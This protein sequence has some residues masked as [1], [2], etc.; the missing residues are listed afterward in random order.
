[1]IKRFK[2]DSLV[3]DVITIL[4]S[5]HD[6]KR[7]SQVLAEKYA[8][9]DVTACI[10]ALMSFGVITVS[11]E[12]YFGRRYQK[13]VLF[14]SE[15]TSSFEEAISSQK[16]LENATVAVFGVGGV[17]TWIVNGL[18]QMGVGNIRITD[19]DI[20]TESNLNRQ[21]YFT[22]QDIGRYKVDVIKGKIP[23][24][25]IQTWKTTVSPHED[26]DHI[27]SGCDI[28]INCADTPS[29]AETTRVVS[30]YATKHNIPYSIAGGY[31]M[32]IGMVGPIFVPG[33]TACF[34]CLVSYLQE[35]D[36]LKGLEVVKGVE[37]T[38]SL[39]P[40]AGVVANLHL[41]EIFKFLTGVSQINYN[42]FAE[43]DFMAFDIK[44]HQ[45]SKRPDCKSCISSTL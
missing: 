5:E 22:A 36:P 42:R 14:L 31:D 38:G 43:I 41:M 23:D 8:A 45:Y 26:L 1:M 40:I 9:E 24:A 11:D 32:H 20:V 34:D 7:V 33:K 3:K 37:Q 44:R 4:L 16:R 13:Q 6:P 21:L 2:V 27:I 18:Y 28:L 30:N 29:V 39:G 10:S 17:G 15:L 12:N 35:I 25:N 19:P